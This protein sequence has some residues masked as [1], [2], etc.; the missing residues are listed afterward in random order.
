MQEVMQSFWRC[1]GGKLTR[2]PDSVDCLSPHSSPLNT[3][4]E[5]QS[6]KRLSFVFSWAGQCQPQQYITPWTRGGYAHQ[7]Q[8]LIYFIPPRDVAVISCVPLA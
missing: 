6:N 7:R 5:S 3:D 8:M 1:D 4:P 2:R